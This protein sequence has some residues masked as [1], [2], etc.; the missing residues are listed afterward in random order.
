M[1]RPGGAGIRRLPTPAEADAVEAAVATGPPEVV[2]HRRVVVRQSGG[3]EY[4]SVEVLLR[5]PAPA[6]RMA[7]IRHRLERS[8]RGALPELVVSVR[9]RVGE[10]PPPEPEDET[11]LDDTRPFD[12]EAGDEQPTEALA[13]PDTEPVL[14]SAPW[15]ER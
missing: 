11:R 14:P 2:G 15:P 7:E 12:A 10:L 5:T 4:L 13:G 3:A 1:G 6:E 8:I 9:I